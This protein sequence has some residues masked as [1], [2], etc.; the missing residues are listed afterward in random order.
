MVWDLW[1]ISMEYS[2]LSRIF[3]LK[4]IEAVNRSLNST[5]AFTENFMFRREIFCKCHNLL[6]L[7]FDWQPL[8]YK[9]KY[10]K[11]EWKLFMRTTKG[12][13]INYGKICFSL[14]KK[15]TKLTVS[16]YIFVP[17]VVCFTD[18]FSLSLILTPAEPSLFPTTKHII[19]LA[20]VTREK[21]GLL[22]LDFDLVTH[23]TLTLCS[24]P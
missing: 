10:P 16:M 5:M 23:H 4:I 17:I 7:K 9:S 24:Q 22:T 18:P 12:Y 8:L 3:H 14:Q 19:S 1:C 21:R 13:R 11:E 6:R 2:H 20:T 15:W